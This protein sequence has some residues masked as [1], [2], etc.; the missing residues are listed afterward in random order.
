MSDNIENREKLLQ[1]IADD[2]I[3]LHRKHPGRY[4]VDD[5][6]VAFFDDA[7]DG[8]LELWVGSVG[9]AIDYIVNDIYCDERGDWSQATSAIVR[10]L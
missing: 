8:P 2:L 9:Q 10:V 1:G 4:K 5:L 3:A 7:E 6:E